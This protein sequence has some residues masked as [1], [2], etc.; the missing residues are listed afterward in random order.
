[1]QTPGA[2]HILSSNDI[3]RLWV[4]AFTILVIV[5][6]CAWFLGGAEEWQ[7]ASWRPGLNLAAFTSAPASTQVHALFIVLLVVTGWLMLALPKGDRRHKLL[8]WTWVG[9]M[10]LMG[11]TSML[12]P[13]GDSWVAAYVGG[14]SALVLMAYGI[15]KIKRRRF[16]DHARTMAMLMI[17]LG[18]MTLLAIVP[19][20]LLHDVFFAG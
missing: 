9:G 14:G 17:A 2:R 18:V 12:V 6:G 11:L 1:M 13:H 10:T 20:R 5:P 16:R 19:G 3:R 15:Y 4:F 8:G 7:H